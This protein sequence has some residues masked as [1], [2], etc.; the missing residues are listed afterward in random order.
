MSPHIR[1][2]YKINKKY[3]KTNRTINPVKSKMLLNFKL[4]L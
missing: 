2:N 3:L 1:F 4:K